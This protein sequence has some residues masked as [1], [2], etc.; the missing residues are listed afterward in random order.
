MKKKFLL[1]TMLF[2]AALSLNKA[3]AQY[4]MLTDFTGIGTFTGANPQYDQ[5]F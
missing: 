1:F 4:T 5:N 3:M 2:V